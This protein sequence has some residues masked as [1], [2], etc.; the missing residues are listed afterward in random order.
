MWTT[1]IFSFDYG[2]NVVDLFNLVLIFSYNVVQ[3]PLGNF[4]SLFELMLLGIPK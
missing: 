1:Y 3:N 2:W 4:V